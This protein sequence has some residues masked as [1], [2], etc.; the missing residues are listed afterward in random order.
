MDEET[1]QNLLKEL[2]YNKN[3]YREKVYYKMKRSY[4][5]SYRTAISELLSILEFRSNNLKHQPVIEALN[6]VKKYIGTRQKYFP[7]N[8][9]VPI[10]EVIPQK[11]IKVVLEKDTKGNPRVNRINY[12]ITVLQSLRDKLRCKEIWVVGADRYRNPDEDLPLDFEE[13][14]QEYYEALGLSMDVEPIIS[15]LQQKLHNKLDQFNRTIPKNPKVSITN[16]RNDWISVSPIEPQKEPERLSQL[17]QVIAKR[18]WLLELI[19]IFKETDLRMNFTGVFQSLAKYER[20]DRAD[21]Q[22][23]LLLCMYGIV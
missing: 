23:R 4:S 2:K 9:D 13:K 16:H 10:N 3:V 6:L 8:D 22:K 11:F 14:R 5:L 1:A 18:W 17:K 19:D 12:E 7:I 20:L 15:E 21:I